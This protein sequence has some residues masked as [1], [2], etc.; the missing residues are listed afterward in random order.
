MYARNGA[1]SALVTDVACMSFGRNDPSRVNTAISHSAAAT[2]AAP[3]SAAAG[4]V[5]R[6]NL[7]HWLATSSAPGLPLDDADGDVLEVAAPELADPLSQPP[8]PSA[9]ATTAATTQGR[10]R[11]PVNAGSPAT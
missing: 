11:R 7:L 3:N 6:L 10:S 9:T 8:T 1:K 4:P 2:F 5:G